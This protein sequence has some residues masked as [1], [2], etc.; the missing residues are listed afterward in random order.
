MK[1]CRHYNV[2][3]VFSSPE[4]LLLLKEIT[5]SQRY[6]VLNRLKLVDFCCQKNLDFPEISILLMMQY[7]QQK[8]TQARLT[9][10]KKKGAQEL[11][12]IKKLCDK[13]FFKPNKAKNN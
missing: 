12:L 2:L 8:E 4:K 7:L 13:F 9:A 11:L 1:L 3:L 6:A 10:L 5:K